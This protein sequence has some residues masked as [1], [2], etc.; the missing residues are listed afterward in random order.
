[1]ELCS[2]GELFDRLAA[3]PGS[4]MQEKT[5]RQ[6]VIKMLRALH[7][8]HEH[9][10]IHRDLKLENFIFTNKKKNADIKLIDFGY[11]RSYLEGEKMTSL[12]GTSFY[13][14]PEVVEGE[15][16]K[17]AD[18]WS[19]GTIIYMLVTGELPI[20]GDCDSEILGNVVRLLDHPKKFGAIANMVP[21]VSISPECSDFINQLMEIDTKKR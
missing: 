18:L 10:I 3:Q 12:V 11:S 6:L 14:A 9:G 21:G 1:M 2:G 17:A 20:A 7:Y 16:T 5:V 13:I 4:R 8:L 19:F 15:Y